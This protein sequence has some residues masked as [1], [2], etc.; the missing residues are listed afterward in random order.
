MTK[1]STR[2]ADE[3]EGQQ[4][5]EGITDVRARELRNRPDDMIILE[6]LEETDFPDSCTWNTFV[7]R[8]QSDLLQ[9]DYPTGINVSR[10]IYDTICAWCHM[11][12][13]IEPRTIINKLGP[14]FANL[15]YLCVILH[16]TKSLK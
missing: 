2:I 1:T 6:L 5:R 8:F 13:S 11:R 16:H 10:L 14:T 12:V 7:F 3:E 15:F 4:G 9:S